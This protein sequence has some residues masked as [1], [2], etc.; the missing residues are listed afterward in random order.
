MEE[1]KNIS[2]EFKIFAIK[3]VCDENSIFVKDSRL[4]EAGYLEKRFEENFTIKK[5]WQR[6][7]YESVKADLLKDSEENLGK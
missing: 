6:K 3:K 7:H 5:R 4:L 1:C 2:N